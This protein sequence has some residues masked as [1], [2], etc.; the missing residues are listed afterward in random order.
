MCILL[1]NMQVIY[2]INNNECTDVV[3]IENYSQ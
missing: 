2:T 3:N 1:Y